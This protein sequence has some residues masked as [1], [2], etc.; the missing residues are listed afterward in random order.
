M[1]Y[2]RRLDNT[3]SALISLE[4]KK[5]EAAKKVVKNRNRLRRLVKELLGEERELS[6]GSEHYAGL[7]KQNGRVSWKSV[8]EEMASDCR[9]PESKLEDYIDRHRS[10]SRRLR[11][12]KISDIDEKFYQLEFDFLTP[13]L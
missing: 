3:I 4:D 10:E 5:Y 8:A 11:Y 1:A 7:Q 12:G 2:S 13:G 6:K 9:I